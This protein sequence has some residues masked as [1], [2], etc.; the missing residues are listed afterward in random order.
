MKNEKALTNRCGIVRVVLLAT[1]LALVSQTAHAGESA[2][3]Q[4]SVNT[5]SMVGNS[6][7]PFSIAIALTDGSGISAGSS[8]VQVAN[9]N[10]N[11]GKTLGSPV[12]FGGA[13]GDLG[14][15]AAITNTSFLGLLVESFLPGSKLTFTLSLT[16]GHNKTGVPDR[17]TIFILDATGAPIATLAPAG[18]FFIGIDLTSEDPAPEV[19]GSDSVRPPFTGIP[20]SIPRPKVSD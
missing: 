11:G 7:G 3:F 1:S 4:V 8:T 2:V 14:S 17:L 13:S 12:L 9:V 5:A 10:F 18:N 16:A 6:A 20:I 15:S 19:F